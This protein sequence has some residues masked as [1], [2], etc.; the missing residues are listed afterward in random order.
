MPV[1]PHDPIMLGGSRELGGSRGARVE[2][3]AAEA[4]SAATALGWNNYAERFNLNTSPAR[5]LGSP[6]PYKA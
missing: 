6:L 4:V 1:L 3:F 5:R 2:V